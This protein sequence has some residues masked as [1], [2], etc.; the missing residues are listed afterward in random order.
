MEDSPFSPD[1]WLGSGEQA[2]AQPEGLEKKQ[3]GLTHS[4]GFSAAD[5]SPSPTVLRSRDAPS[6]YLVAPRWL[7]QECSVHALWRPAH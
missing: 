6:P 5:A 4:L 3:A 1:A 2:T 7:E